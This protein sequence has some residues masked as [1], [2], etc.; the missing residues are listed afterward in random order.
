VP[1]QEASEGVTRVELG[2]DAGRYWLIW[3]TEF[4]PG[5]GEGAINEVR[6]LEP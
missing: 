1:G 5:S 3:I 6:F 4:A 2:P